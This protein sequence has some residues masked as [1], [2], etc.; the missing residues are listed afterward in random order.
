MSMIHLLKRMSFVVFYLPFILNHICFSCHISGRFWVAWGESSHAKWDRQ[1]SLGMDDLAWGPHPI[2][3]RHM[4][5]IK[6]LVLLWTSEWLIGW[7]CQTLREPFVGWWDSLTCG[8][9]VLS[10]EKIKNMRFGV[11]CVGLG[12]WERFPTSSKVAPPPYHLFS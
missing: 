6:T 2:H 9:V 7:S 4:W 10:H 8:I 5:Q 11:G 1:Y 12:R 3:P